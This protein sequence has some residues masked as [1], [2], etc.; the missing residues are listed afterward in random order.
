MLPAHGQ[1]NKNKNKNKKTKKTKNKTVLIS[2][3]KS[4]QSRGFLTIMG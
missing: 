1:K 3:K 2:K 4:F